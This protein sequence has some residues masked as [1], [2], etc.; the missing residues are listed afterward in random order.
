LPQEREFAVSSISYK[1][2]AQQPYT[3]HTPPYKMKYLPLLFALATA[4]PR[5]EMQ[6]HTPQPPQPLPE[7]EK[8]AFR[9]HMKPTLITGANA[10]AAN[11]NA[12]LQENKNDLGLAPPE[13]K[14]QMVERLVNYTVP[15]N[16]THKAEIIE[17][18]LTHISVATK[19]TEEIEGSPANA[20]ITREDMQ[21]KVEIRFFAPNDPDR[22]VITIPES[23]ETI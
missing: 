3:P 5:S 20:N 21:A 23:A 19:N 13:I 14:V 4:L 16:A 15:A 22:E 8:P 11:E 9:L 12:M 1:A 17:G 7:M 2:T 18:R 6:Q 10:D